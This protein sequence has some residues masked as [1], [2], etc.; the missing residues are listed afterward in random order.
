LADTEAASESIKASAEEIGRVVDSESKVLR[1]LSALTSSEV[2]DLGAEKDKEALADIL[3]PVILL[4]RIQLTARGVVFE[5]DEIP[6]WKLACRPAALIRSLLC[7]LFRAVEALAP[8]EKKKVSF[9]FSESGEHLAIAIQASGLT[10]KPDPGIFPFVDEG[11]KKH[12]ESVIRGHGGTM[13]V[14]SGAEPPVRL[15][16]R[17]RLPVEKS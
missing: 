9:R 10:E 4:A 17:I 13:E 3:E 15:S 8:F 1:A 7:L 14:L 12:V 6:G 5:W 2:S 16:I 11:E